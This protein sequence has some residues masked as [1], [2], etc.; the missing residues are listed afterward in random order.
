MPLPPP[1]WP[2]YS[3]SSRLSDLLEVSGSLPA[4]LSLPPLPFSL[5]GLT[6]SGLLFRLHAVMID[7][8]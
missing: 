2:L 6:K 3:N 4:I 1:P 8:I 5:C 7:D